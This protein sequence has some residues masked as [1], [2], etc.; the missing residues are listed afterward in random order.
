MKFA[1]HY[2]WLLQAASGS[3]DELAHSGAEGDNPGRGNRRKQRRGRNMQG[4][5]PGVF[6][7][8]FPSSLRA[9]EL[10][11]QVHAPTYCLSIVPLL[12]TIMYWLLNWL[13]LM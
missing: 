7:G 10:K 2:V 11:S 5:L 9:S 6:V 1:L 12:E 4:P 3:D 13:S 8:R